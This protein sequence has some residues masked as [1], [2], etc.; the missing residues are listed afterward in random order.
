MIVVAILGILA[1]LAVPAF[2]HFLRR[3]KSAEVSANLSGLFETAASYYNIIHTSTGMN[4]ENSLYC[5]VPT[6]PPYPPPSTTK[7][8]YQP[9]D[10]ARALGFTIANPVYYAYHIKA[11]PDSGECEHIANDST[12]YTFSAHGDLDGDGLES[13]FELAVGTD[14]S[15][16]LYRA[17]GFYI[18]NDTE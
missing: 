9:T 4:E 14:A 6:D 5:L 16:A 7:H 13:R 1:A 8:K 17:R 12:I 10:S 18:V 2:A 11:D 15:N 3:S